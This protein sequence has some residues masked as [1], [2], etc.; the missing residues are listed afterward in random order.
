VDDPTVFTRVWRGEMPLNHIRERMFEFACHEGNYA[1]RGILG[2]ARVD[3]GA[4][5]LR[6]NPQD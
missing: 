3:G 4:A 5:G 6:S 1:L 2:G